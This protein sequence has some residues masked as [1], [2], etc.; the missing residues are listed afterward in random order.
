MSEPR[1]DALVFFGAT[2]DLA[3]KKIFPALQT[4]ARRGRLDCPGHRRREGRLESRSARGARA[5][6]RRGV[7]RGVDAAA[8]ATLVGAPALRRRR[9]QRRR[10]PSRSCAPQLRGAAR[11]AH[12]LA[13]PPS[14]FPAVVEAASAGRAAPT[15]HA[16]IVEK[17]FGRDLASA[18]ALNQT[19]HDVLPRGA[20]SSASTTTSARRRSRTSSSSASRTRSSSRSWNRQLRRERADHDGRELRR[21]GPRPVLRGD[22]RHSR[23]DP[24]PPAAGRQL[25]RDGGALEHLPRG[26]PRRA[27]EGAAHRAPAA[28]RATWC[29]ASSAAT[30]TSRTSRPT[31]RWRPSPRCGCY[32]DSWRWEGVPFYVRAGKSPRDDRHRGDGGAAPARR[33][34]CSRR[35]R[36]SGRQLRPLPAQPEG[37]DRASAPARSRRARRWWASPSSCRVMQG[38]E[39]GKDGRIGPYERLL[40]DA[41]AGDPTLFARA[42]RGRGGVGDRRPGPPRRRSRCTRTSPARWGPA[43]ADALVTEVGGWNTPRA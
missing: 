41:M 8:F 30:A 29:A 28:H 42:G 25:P 5:R 12:Y 36:R 13:I 20:R 37:R 40:G 35:R 31:R 33:R 2:G 10:A 26:D 11:P 6:Q 7:R 9:L 14:L 3:Y 21:E 39:Q 19:I 34:S 4:M 24:E 23:R 38:P 22:G 17:P 15:T 27:G 1:S 43:E 16:S 18:R 32:V